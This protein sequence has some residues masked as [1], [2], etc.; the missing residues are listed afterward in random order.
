MLRHERKLHKKIVP[1]S[2][3][4]K[5]KF[6]EQHLYLQH[7]NIKLAHRYYYYSVICRML[8]VDCLVQLER[9]FDI[10]ANTIEQHLKR[11]E[12]LIQKL[13]DA[14]TPVSELKQKYPWFDWSKQALI[15]IN[16]R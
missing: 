2:L 16:L 10:T 8:Y 1:N 4:A 13:A 9:E 12:A 14:K 15:P 6:Q 5:G 3:P 7:R 11:R